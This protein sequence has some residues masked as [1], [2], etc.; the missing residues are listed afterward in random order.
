MNFSNSFMFRMIEYDKFHYTDN[1]SGISTHF[2]AYMISGDCKINTETE[3]IEVTAG[4]CFYL[5]DK[6]KYESFWYGDP[7]IKFVSLAFVYMPELDNKSY[8]VQKFK[9]TDE[10]KK[11]FALLAESPAAVSSYKIGIFY[12]LAATLIP[13]M[14]HVSFCKSRE[15]VGKARNYWLSHPHANASEISENCAVSESALYA[16]FKKA[17]GDTPNA[18]RNQIM[19]EEAKNMLI[20]TDS[21]IEYISSYLGFSSSSYFRKKFKNYYGMTPK[22]IRKKY[23]I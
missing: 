11:L 12:T 7:D 18:M 20:C 14:K 5:P 21:S 3:S 22:E 13:Q 8:P 2:F 16:A 19:L 15:I 23:R 4:D 6:L 1:R 10:A 9:P 17:T